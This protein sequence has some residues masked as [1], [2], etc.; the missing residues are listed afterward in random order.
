MDELLRPSP[1]E[2]WGGVECT[3]NR[4][5]DRYF[6][7]LE[8]N[9]H[10]HRLSDLDLFADIGFRALRYPVI[11][12][13]LAPE[14]PDVI[15][16]SFPDERLTRLRELGI[17]PI[18]GL[19]H[20][21]SG[22]RYANIA[23]P[24]FAPGLAA[25]ATRVAQRYPWL[26][27]YTP[28]NEPLT[29]ARFCGL[30]G[31]WHPHGCDNSSFVRILLNECRATTEAMQAIRKINP[32]ARL[33]QTDDL[34]HIYSTPKLRYQA[35]FENERRWLS[36]DLL[37]GR[38]DRQHSMWQYLL[39]SGAT[40]RELDWFCENPCPPDVMGI[41]HYPTS[42]RYLDEELEKYAPC[43]WGSNGRES[44]ADV[45]AVRV[46]PTPP[47]GF[48]ERLCEAWQ[49][50]NLPLAITEAHLGCTREEQVRWTNDAWKAAQE[51]Q[52]GGVD[53]RAVTAWSLLGAW[54][55]NTLVTR[56]V[57]YYE[58]G[59]FDIRGGAPRPTAIAHLLRDLAHGEEH[60]HPA[61]DQLGWWRRP[62]RILDTPLI[63]H[64]LHEATLKNG[65]ELDKSMRPLLI[66]GK[67]GA[68]GKAFA[69]SCD[70]RG[71][72]YYLLSRKEIDL[73][74][75]M[76]LELALDTMR[77]WAVINATGYASVDG[78]E[79]E[80][81][82][83]YRLNT[84]AA[85]NLAKACARRGVALTCFSSDLV[86]DGK[87]DAPYVEQDATRPLN[88]FGKSKALME[89]QVTAAHPSAL[90][91]RA[92][93]LFG[94][95]SQRNFITRT[96]R[97]I[98]QGETTTMAND[99]VVSPTYVPDL[100]T[101][102]LDL[103]I[104]NAGG[105]WHLANE[106]AISWYDFVRLAASHAGLNGPIHGAPWKELPYPAVRPAFSALGSTYGQILPS[107]DSALAEFGQGVKIRAESECVFA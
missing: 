70:L 16:W 36:F 20:H 86:F 55:W 101:A 95:N 96:L 85:A 103:M 45:E 89:E 90:V 72:P 15:D 105:I 26:D 7:Q 13:A 32:R 67:N 28:V 50:Y 25:F 40:P 65:D 83:C 106:G 84:E 12:D 57:N 39:E 54:N 64:R 61:V 73:C 107:L 62:Q 74:D 63:S 37:C 17:R 68:L 79:S 46:L 100:V 41:N 104:D 102:T 34:G 88:V 42:D 51:L 80:S 87:K 53:V 82:L 23:T 58:P 59:V 81:E 1:L 24:D 98:A 2:L 33:V 66:I 8:W 14:R 9:G 22:P 11:W 38:V 10:N 30:Y 78:A 71:L 60:T 5:G 56:D 21:G 99:I 69:R 44:Y 52:R 92:S 27:D 4:V 48:R 76:S 18:A 47:G 77:P 94:P 49:R 35:D 93:A 31:H 29:T 6:N 43:S 91:V 3:F 75:M 97:A 19:V